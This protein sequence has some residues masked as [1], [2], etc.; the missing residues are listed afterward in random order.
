MFIHSLQESGCFEY[1]HFNDKSITYTPLE[2]NEKQKKGDSATDDTPCKLTYSDAARTNPD[3]LITAIRD[4][5]EE[6]FASFYAGYAD[7]LV[8]FLAK[9]LRSEEDAKDVAQ[10]T[11]V[12]LWEGRDNLN[13][14]RNMNSY[15]FTIARNAAF[16]TMRSKKRDM[17]E[18]LETPSYVEEFAGSAD[19]NIISQET[20]LLIEAIIAMMPP[21]RRKIFE[22]SRIEGLTY[23]EIAERLHIS[24]STVRTHIELAKDEIRS[25][26]GVF[27]FILF[28]S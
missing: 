22:M 14:L 17:E 27:L 9:I 1:S 25:T 12:Q 6:A 15:V 11:F 20:I 21:Q 10:E 2:M 23:N 16:K 26:L 4:G 8:H 5:N 18:T 7:S 3:A 19:E 28:L 13:P 24:S